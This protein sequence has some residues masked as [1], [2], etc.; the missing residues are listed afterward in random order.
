M[1]GWSAVAHRRAE[2]ARCVR[3]IRC[4]STALAQGRSPPATA[5]RQCRPRS[6]PHLYRSWPAVSQICALMVLPSVLMLLVA[7]STP[8]VDLDSKLNSLRVKRDRRFDF[9]TPES[10][11]N[12]T[13]F[14]KRG[15][16]GGVEGRGGGAAWVRGREGGRR[17]GRFFSSAIIIRRHGYIGTSTEHVVLL[18]AMHQL[19]LY[20]RALVL[21]AESRPEMAPPVH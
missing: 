5:A 16:R 13:V 1:A 4:A 8:I 18:A 21:A 20:S 6:Q 2:Y 12:T 7:N 15:G 9:P 10:P 11:I 17:G 3:H 14:T 19:L